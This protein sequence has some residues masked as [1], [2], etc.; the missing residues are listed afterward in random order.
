[1][2]MTAVKAISKK[3]LHIIPL[4][5][6]TAIA[7]R[8]TIMDGWDIPGSK[9]PT[10]HNRLVENTED[11][12]CPLIP[13][14]HR[15]NRHCRIK[16]MILKAPQRV[17]IP[18]SLK[19]ENTRILAGI[20]IPMNTKASCWKNSGGITVGSFNA[21]KAWHNAMDNMQKNTRLRLNFQLITAKAANKAK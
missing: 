14:H 20:N 6:N 3:D 19:K 5:I 13:D 4:V 9:L 2:G 15:N 18:L 11:K 21:S 17:K 8:L 7:R 1:M 16:S 10:F 12:L